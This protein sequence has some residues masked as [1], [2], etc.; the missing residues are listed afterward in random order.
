MAA[1]RTMEAHG[2]PTP[3]WSADGSGLPPGERVI[4]K[5]NWEDASVGIYADSVVDAGAA[6]TL[7]ADCV[8]REGG[9]WFAEVFVDGREFNLSILDGPG[10]PELLPAAETLFVDFPA[11]RPRI[12]DYEAKWL[13]E[14]FA[15]AHTPRRF[16]F[17]PADAALIRRLDEL[18]R[19]C[20][21]VFGL[22]GY[23]RIDFRV[24]PERGPMV[25]EIN[26]N[27]CLSP[28]AG[29]AAAAA[30]AGLDL[31]QVV[32]RIIQAAAPGLIPALGWRWRQAVEPS[33]VEAV[34]RLVADTGFFNAEEI[35]VAAE[36]V[37]ERL[38]RGDASGYHFVVAEE[39]DGRL[40]GYACHGPIA[41]APGRSNLYWIVVRPDRQRSGLG[42]ALLDRV[43][44]AVAGAGGLRLYAETAGRAQ[45][46]PSRGFYLGCGFRQEAELAD[47]YGDGDAK[48]ILVKILPG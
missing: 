5:P 13:P 22:A 11:D 47:F 20:W 7:L 40:A 12:V 38:E 42:R 37:E 19:L 3:A 4:V 28:D 26:G 8:R 1:K 48:V 29:F 16:D 44:A 27:P 25:L 31:C 15:F 46:A 2:I 39:A 34:R 41:G 10:G 23:A 43:E 30:A 36:L 14:G 6:A 24:D 45:Y 9:S 17:P 18:A 21:R 35:A 32:T 33:D